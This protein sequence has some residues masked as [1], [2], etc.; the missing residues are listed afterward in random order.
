MRR[1][2][3]DFIDLI[4]TDK[5]EQS[6]RVRQ[7]LEQEVSQGLICERAVDQSEV[8]QGSK[9]AEHVLIVSMHHIVSDAW[10]TEVFIREFSQLYDAFSQGRSLHCRR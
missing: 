9:E 4:D 5:S 1:C 10:S 3:L 7:I 2:R 8:D 6:H